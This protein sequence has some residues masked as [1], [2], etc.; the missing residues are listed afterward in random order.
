[1]MCREKQA[2][3]LPRDLTAAQNEMGRLQN[4]L[5]HVQISLAASRFSRTT[6][7]QEYNRRIN[8]LKQK[9]EQ[10]QE[11]I[12]D[13][14]S[15]NLCTISLFSL[16]VIFEATYV[17]LR[18]THDDAQPASFNGTKSGIPTDN[19]QLTRED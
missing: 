3:N 11:M 8:E 4:Q 19:E 15:A 9:L 7:R 6:D 10:Q 18:S 5:N 13:F 17:K 12:N 2:N 16:V 1:M 14:I